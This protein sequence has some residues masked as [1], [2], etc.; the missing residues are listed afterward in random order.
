[1]P[2]GDYQ[3]F[4]ATRDYVRIKFVN[5]L[6]IDTLINSN[7][8]LF[9]DA[10]YNLE[11]DAGEEVSDPFKDI[12]QSRDYS[13]ISRILTLWW[14]NPPP[15]G[16]Y[17]LDVSNLRS[18]VGTI[19]DDFQ[20][21]ITW[22]LESATPGDTMLGII[23]PDRTPSEVEDYS[24]KSPGWTVEETVDTTTEGTAITILDVAP[25]IS[26]HHYL[27]PQANEGRIDILFS[28]PIAMNYLTSKYFA[29]SRKPVKKGLAQWEALETPIISDVTSS[30]ISVYLPAAEASLD[31][32]TPIYSYGLSDEE[33]ATHEFF[34]EQY[35]YRLIVS[36]AIGI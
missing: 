19:L 3:W 28:S 13:S 12:I 4:E 17:I 9:K 16:D 11:I 10:N 29:L 27:D 30:I 20:I 6:N 31:S 22:K 36:K 15:A 2:L 5:T 34:L 18:F 33:V 32:A 24:I 8:R 21:S 26:T 23:P 35:K 1:M 7:F 25:P 14:D